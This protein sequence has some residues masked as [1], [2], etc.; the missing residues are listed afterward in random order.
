MSEQQ[1]PPSYPVPGKIEEQPQVIVVQQSALTGVPGTI[2][3][4]AGAPGQ[5]VIIV[6]SD[7]QADGNY[8]L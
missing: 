3:V 5:Q 7:A 1:Q 4:P 6:Q 2:I 8:L